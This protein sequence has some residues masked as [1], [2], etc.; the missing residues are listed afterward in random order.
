MPV[1]D[2]ALLCRADHADVIRDMQD[3]RDATLLRNTN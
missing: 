2:N 3:F 1:T